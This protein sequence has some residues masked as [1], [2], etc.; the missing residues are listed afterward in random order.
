MTSSKSII[1]IFSV[2]L[3]LFWTSLANEGLTALPA[4]G[5]SPYENHAFIIGIGDYKNW[6]KLESPVKDAEELAKILL[7]KYDFKKSNV[8]LLTDK[9]KEKPTLL[10]VLTYLEEYTTQLTDKDNLLIFFSGHSVEDDKGETYWVPM[11]GKKKT[12]MT[13]LRHTDL[14][15]EVF[16]SKDFKA[17]S[18]VI[19][20]N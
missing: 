20:T 15:V 6:P 9:T 3:I 10:N 4:G 19:L 14:C 8:T 11:D 13:W 7:E 17:K 1:L 12:R 18:L 2:F 5:D 16:A